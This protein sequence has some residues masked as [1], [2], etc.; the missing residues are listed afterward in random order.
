MKVLCDFDG[1]AARNDVGFLL[2]HTF[3]RNGCF[4]L[5]KQWKAGKISSKECLIQECRLVQVTKEELTQFAD[6]QKLDPSFPEFVH[7]CVR[8]DI[9][10][11]IVSDGF[12]FYIKRILRNYGLD[13]L[14][15][16]Y[17]NRL[18][19]GT[20]RTIVP[21]FPYFPKSCG[22]CANCK[23]F[24]VREAKSSGHEVIYIG[25][26]LSDRCGARAADVVFAKLG[27]DLSSF[28][29]EK[30]IPHFEF[31]DFGDIMKSFKQISDNMD[32]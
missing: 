32:K 25:D 22:R 27:R 31:R 19:F 20:N 6:T 16:F 17:A 12:D 1:T 3:A 29:H 4:E 21:S 10:V 8:R 5:V 18:T 13:A 24:H 2:F 23:G 14:I 7:F 30:E 26:G 15:S 11:V 9:E 28:C